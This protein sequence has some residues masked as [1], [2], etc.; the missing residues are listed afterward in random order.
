MEST[1]HLNAELVAAVGNCRSINLYCR[2]CRKLPSSWSYHSRYNWCVS[3]YCDK[4]KKPWYVCSICN[5]V[6]CYYDKPESLRFHATKYHTP[7]ANEE[8]NRLNKKRNRT[9]DGCINS[10]SDVVD[11]GSESVECNINVDNLK[12]INEEDASGDLPPINDDSTNQAN[13]ETSID[14]SYEFN[15]SP[16]DL[17]PA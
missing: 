9:D 15:D 4:C 10:E 5:S 3:L 8:S 7:I 11:D 12:D 14:D 6:R 16:N 13:K 17:L 1:A 2:T